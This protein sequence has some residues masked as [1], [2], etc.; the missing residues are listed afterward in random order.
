MFDS[1]CLAKIPPG[2]PASLTIPDYGRVAWDPSV[3]GKIM[4][5]AMSQSA[6]SGLG[7]Y[8]ILASPSPCPAEAP[9]ENNPCTTS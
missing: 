9:P 6:G 8:D 4:Q 2:F 3:L 1:S 5:T 7:P